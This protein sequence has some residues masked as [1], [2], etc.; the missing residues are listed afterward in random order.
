MKINIVAFLIYF[1]I[2]LNG[3]I[4]SKPFPPKTNQEI[5]ID[6]LF[7]FQIIDPYRWLENKDDLEVKQW[8]KAQHKFTLDFIQTTTKEIVNLVDE[9][10]KYHDRNYTSQP[11][12]KSNRDFFYKSKKGE[13]QNKLYARLHR[14]EILRFGPLSN[15][16]S[17]EMAISGFVPTRKVDKAAIGVQTRGNEISRYYFIDMKKE[18]GI[19]PPLDNVY[20]LSWRRDENFVYVTHR[21]AKEI[22]L[23]KSLKTY[24]HRL[25]S[26]A[27]ED[28]FLLS[29]KDSKDFASFYDDEDSDFTVISKGDFFTNTPNIRK[30]NAKDTAQVV[31]S[32][33]QT[34][35]S[36]RFYR[37]RLYYFTNFEAP[38]YKLLMTSTYLSNF[39]SAK[40]VITEME[41]HIE[42]FGITSDY[43]ILNTRKDAM[44]KLYVY[45]HDG[46]FIQELTFPKFGNIGSLNYHK[47]NNTIYVSFMKFTDPS[48]VYKLDGKTLKWTFFYQNESP[49]NTSEITAKLIFYNSKNETRIPMFIAHKNVIK[50]DGNNPTLLYGYGGFNIP[51]TLHYLD[52]TTS[53]IIRGGVYA[54]ACLRGGNEYG[55]NW[56][57]QGM[58][59]NK[60]NIFDDYISADEY[61]ITNGYTAPNILAMQCGNNGGLLVASVTTQRPDFFKSV[62][63]A[64]TLLD[65][66]RFHKFLI[67]RYWIAEYG[68]LDKEEDLPYLL[69][70][71]P[72][73]NIRTDISLSTMLIKA[74]E[75]DTRV[76]TSHAKKIRCTFPKFTIANQYNLGICRF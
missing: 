76:D 18:K 37:D 51:M 42:C 57:K 43:L 61:L 26:T 20:N 53:F 50:L 7:S 28:G 39:H 33:N 16:S 64:V 38:N 45:D 4:F 63:C 68:H 41:Y 54:V 1:L 55:E 5:S 59:H 2:L 48:K 25:G 24:P 46:N 34:R 8:N 60:H 27:N 66:I 32:S 74:G 40:T 71:S 52:L 49:L 75:N 21:S 12:L 17:G 29:S 14:K 36:V 15:D 13:Q 6:S 67:E 19:A 62:V 31:F 58:L 69:S 44:S 30:T 47:K 9:I 65:K 22:I 10:K 11:F 72:Y 73:H 23:Q 56:Y 70:Y 35:A 3:Q